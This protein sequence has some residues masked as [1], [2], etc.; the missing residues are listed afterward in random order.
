MR[1]CLVRADSSASEAVPELLEPPLVGEAEGDRVRATPQVGRLS[2]FTFARGGGWFG[3]AVEPVRASGRGAQIRQATFWGEI[4]ALEALMEPAWWA[5]ALHAFWCQVAITTALAW[6]PRPR[7]RRMP[8]WAALVT[9]ERLQA[10]SIR[11]EC[12][13]RMLCG[14]YSDVDP[15]MTMREVAKRFTLGRSIGH[16]RVAQIRNTAL[17][18]LGVTAPSRSA[19]RLG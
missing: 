3:W 18:K 4:A 14:Q 1:S 19:T 17:A 11:E 12:I 5:S 6:E 10:L 2:P 16:A 8:A 9:R 15:P 13:L 7:P